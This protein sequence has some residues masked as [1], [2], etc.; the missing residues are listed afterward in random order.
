MTCPIGRR[1]SKRRRFNHSWR[2]KLDFFCPVGNG[3]LDREIF[4]PLL[5][6]EALI[7]KGRR[8]YNTL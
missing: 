4:D 6:A 1:Q 7:E 5:E 2:S 3:F 8:E